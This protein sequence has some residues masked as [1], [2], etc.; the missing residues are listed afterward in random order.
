[1]W[2]SY[3]KTVA[4]SDSVA[5]SFISI[6]PEYKNKVIVIENILLEELIRE[7]ALETVKDFGVDTSIRLLS[8]GGYS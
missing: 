4:A 7:Q 5:E 3:D 6:F 8:I 2:A 1:M